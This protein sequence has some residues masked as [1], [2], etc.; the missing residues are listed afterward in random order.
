MKLHKNIFSL[1][2]TCFNSIESNFS[3]KLIYISIVFK[4]KLSGIGNSRKRS[5]KLSKGPFYYKIHPRFFLKKHLSVKI[6]YF[7]LYTITGVSSVTT[8]IKHIR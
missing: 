4:G 5:L 6:H 7:F 3:E 8:I 1:I 2:Q